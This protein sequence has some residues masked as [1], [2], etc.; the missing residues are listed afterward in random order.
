VLRG[1][2]NVAVLREPTAREVPREVVKEESEVALIRAA[3]ASLNAGEP[4]RAL[5]LLEAHGA[6]YPSG[7]MGRERAGL[8]VLALCAMG[9][10]QEG[11]R[12]QAAFLDAASD[13]PLQHRVRRACEPSGDARE[14]NRQQ[15]R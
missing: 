3:F 4:Q 14:P 9:R 6:R 15:S 7:A 13:S 10:L 2:A 5:E 12:E 11:R 1:S 8:R